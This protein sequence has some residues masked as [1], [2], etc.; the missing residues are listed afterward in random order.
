[1]NV[2]YYRVDA[3][4]R[5]AFRGNPASVVM[6]PDWLDDCTLQAIAAEENAA[7]TAFVVATGDEFALRWFAPGSELE[8]CGHATLAAGYV[9]LGRLRDDRAGVTFATRAGPLQARRDGDRVGLDFPALPPRN[10]RPVQEVSGALGVRVHAVW[11]APGARALAVLREP[12]RVREMRPN[13]TA[14]AA[15]PYSALIVTAR[16]L[17]D[18]CDFISRYFAPKHGI[19]EDSVTGSA[20][21]VLTPYWAAVLEKPVL[22]A[23]Q[24][25]ARGGELWVEDCGDRVRIAGQCVPIAHG[26]LTLP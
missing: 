10:E 12:V 23:R 9:L 14:I 4:T 20:H 25:S 2:P 7:A 22:F 19:A 8:L 24:V 15:L 6:L 3:F 1:M 18:D 11:E 13:V 5:T 17:E 16:G 21:C 26:T